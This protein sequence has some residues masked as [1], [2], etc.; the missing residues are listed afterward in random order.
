MTS[1][2]RGVRFNTIT[3]ERTPC[4]GTCP[5]YR[6]E[7]DS[8]GTVRYEGDINVKM[9]GHHEW[10]IPHERV[11]KLEEALQ[12]Y[13]FFD[14]EENLNAGVVTDMSS[15]V[16]TVHMSDGRQRTI[17]NTYGTDRFPPSL[18][19]FENSIDRLSGALR[20]VTGKDDLDP[21]VM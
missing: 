9:T 8:D 2:K 12:K 4:Y 14:I 6:I 18:Y 11:E 7:I 13:R 21:P 15:C 1:D 19:K 3:L 20:Y 5:V 10:T 17:E 16:T